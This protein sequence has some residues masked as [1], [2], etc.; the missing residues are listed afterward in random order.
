[1]AEYLQQVLDLLDINLIE[2]KHG[3]KYV[4]HTINIVQ[5]N[6]VTFRVN[7]IVLPIRYIYEHFNIQIVKLYNISTKIQPADMGENTISGHLI[8]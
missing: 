8:K 7:H 6:C 2:P 5:S 3:L 4:Q 1:M